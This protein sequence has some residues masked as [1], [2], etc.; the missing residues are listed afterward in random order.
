MFSLLVHVRYCWKREMEKER[1]REK[2]GE[3][4]EQRERQKVEREKKCARLI[5]K[6]A[7]LIEREG[8]LKERYLYVQRDKESVWGRLM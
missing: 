2:E 8:T 4:D 7:G 3:T 5:L 1:E 6:W